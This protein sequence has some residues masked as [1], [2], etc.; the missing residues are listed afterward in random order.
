[1]L[2]PSIYICYPFA[3]LSLVIKVEHRS[4]RIDAQ[5]IHM[6]LAQPVEGVSNEEIAHLAPPIIKDQRTP[7]LVLTLTPVAVLVEM[8]AVKVAQRMP[9]FGKVARHP[10]ENDTNA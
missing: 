1:M 2:T 5:P 3:G 8:S 4:H 6:I 7:I 9:I 10:V